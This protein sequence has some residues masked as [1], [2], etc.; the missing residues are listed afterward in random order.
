MAVKKTMRV[1]QRKTVKPAVFIIMAVLFLTS[2]V[3]SVVLFERGSGTGGGS[4]ANYYPDRGSEV[5]LEDMWLMETGLASAPGRDAL[6][7]A[8]DNSSSYLFWDTLDG[9]DPNAPK[10]GEGD[11][12]DAIGINGSLTDGGNVN[13]GRN[14]N[15][16]ATSSGSAGGS[17]RSGGAPATL[18]KRGNFSLDSG[19]GGGSASTVGKIGGVNRQSLGGGAVVA[20]FNKAE[21]TDPNKDIKGR[22]G[23]VVS[24][25]KDAK[26]AAALT[27][28]SAGDALKS[29]SGRA[30]DGN[31][32]NNLGVKTDDKSDSG[33]SVGADADTLFPS[34]GGEIQ[35]RSDIT[36]PAVDESNLKEEEKDDGKSSSDFWMGL[37]QSIIQTVVGAAANSI[38]NSL[39]PSSSGSGTK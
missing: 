39:F 17:G 15:P 25:L 31:A 22:K 4:R 27:N 29:A 34:S 19:G 36:P 1:V 21:A 28:A 10:E 30:F 24:E 12:A 14:P 5:D 13:M 37:L 23:G 32:K 20:N 9:K 6:S 16:G 2:M 26:T 35:M 11:D 7:Q 38:A 33:V 18:S 8:G 3:A